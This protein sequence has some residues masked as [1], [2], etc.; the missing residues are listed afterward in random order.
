MGKAHTITVVLFAASLLL[1]ACTAAPQAP[2][3]APIPTPTPASE[4]A[5]TPSRAE[6]AKTVTPPQTSNPELGNQSDPYN[7][8][9]SEDAEFVFKEFTRLPFDIENVSAV[10]PVGGFGGSQVRNNPRL[11]RP[12]GTERHFIWHKTPGTAYNVYAPASTYI[13]SVRKSS[14]IGDYGLDFRMY[15][16]S[17]FRLDHIHTLDPE[18]KSKID[19]QLGGWEETSPFISLP[20]PIPVR[21]GDILGQTGIKDNSV[22]WDWLVE[23]HTQHE[24]VT[25]PEHYWSPVF[26]YSRSVY[27]LCTEEVKRQLE[28]LAGYPNQPQKGLPILGQFGSDVAGTLSGTWFNSYTNDPEW[29]PR[30][31]V[32]RP[33]FLDSGQIEIKL[34]IPELDLYGVWVISPEKSGY[35]PNPRQVTAD[36]G[37]A[38][39]LLEPANSSEQGEY[40]LLM[41]QVTADGS[42]RL[43]THRDSF[44][45]EEY[46]AFSGNELTLTR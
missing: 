2:V 45:P 14:G 24:G 27:E 39:Y 6:T 37:I 36:S 12:Y 17:Q 11:G 21:A 38:Y 46:P 32:F 25:Y 19:A 41:A 16:E 20:V 34:A 26:A 5:E 43:E 31:A 40:G 23:D 44:N 22:N 42:I 7:Q 13:V 28:T 1:L 18:L 30:I 4:A 33:Y 35:Q 10:S 29:G 3:S 15:G 9:A 8:S